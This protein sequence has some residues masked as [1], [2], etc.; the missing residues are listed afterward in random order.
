MESNHYQCRGGGTQTSEYS[1]LSRWFQSTVMLGHQWY[2]AKCGP[3]GQQH[4]RHLELIRNANSQFPPETYWFRTSGD[5]AQTSVLT[6]SPGEHTNIWFSNS[7]LHWFSTWD[8]CY[9]DFIWPQ[10][11]SSALDK[12]KLFLGVILWCG[13]LRIRRCHCSGLGHWCGM[14][15]IPGPGTSTSHGHGQ[16]PPP[17]KDTHTHTHTHTHTESI[18][19]HLFQHGEIGIAKRTLIRESRRGTNDIQKHKKEFMA[20]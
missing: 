16:P 12:S 14:G 1:K 8:C 3:W 10:K 2:R 18:I 9:H 5:G 6:S 19:P 7:K 13:G 20:W 15:L 11:D 4:Q 17:K